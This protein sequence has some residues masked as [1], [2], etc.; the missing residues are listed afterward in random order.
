MKIFSK[1]LVAL[2]VLTSILGL[3][4]FASAAMDPVNLG[5]ANNFTILAGTKITN[6]GPSVITGNTG[7]S[8]AAGSFYAGLTT[9][10]VTGTIYAVDTSGPAGSISDPGML[11]IAKNDLTAAYLD[12]A[13]RTAT[14]TFVATDNQLG[15]RT[16]TSGVYAF[17]H[18][19]TAN[20]T[21]ATPLILDGQGDSNAIFI[22]QASSDLITA[23]GSVV[24]LTGGAQPC[25]VFWQVTSSATLGSGSTFVGNILALTSIGLNTE[26]NVDG[27]LLARNGAVTLDDNDITGNACATNNTGS[28]GTT[29][30]IP[31]LP[32]TGADMG[33]PWDIILVT[34]ML[35]GSLLFA[36]AIEKYESRKSS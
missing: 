4:G 6:T 8:P 5:T 14:N 25:N 2:F 17:G 16:L 33:D 30:I 9:T 12:A 19:N 34:G 35:I 26:A 24:T 27:K 15:G 31:K 21:A 13:G 11:T 28:T 20:L 29:T 7:L 36:F 1:L 18:A 32:N 23:S 22:F 10:H 3:G